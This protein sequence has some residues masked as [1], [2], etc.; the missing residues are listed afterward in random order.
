M[1][2]EQQ[3]TTFASKKQYYI[4]IKKSMIHLKNITMLTRSVVD[5]FVFILDLKIF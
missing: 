4:K 1:R 3:M 2:L 5:N